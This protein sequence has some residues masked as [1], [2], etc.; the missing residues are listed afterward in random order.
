MRNFLITLSLLIVTPAYAAGPLEVGTLR[1]SE[2]GDA[3]MKAI[4]YM[5]VKASIDAWILSYVME[6][7][8]D[9]PEAQAVQACYSAHPAKDIALQ[10]LET[11]ENDMMLVLAVRKE[12]DDCMN[13]KM[14]LPDAEI[15]VTGWTTAPQIGKKPKENQECAAIWD[16]VCRLTRTSALVDSGPFDQYWLNVRFRG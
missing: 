16:R 15:L 8:G 9:T 4:G 5:M 10:V 11:Y 6:Y 14:A 12:M 7:E 1:Q 2:A 3:Q 13:F